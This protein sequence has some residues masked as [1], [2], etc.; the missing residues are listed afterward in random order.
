M[1][2]PKKTKNISSAFFNTIDFTAFS[3]SKVYEDLHLLVDKIAT[4]PY[5]Y[6]YTWPWVSPQKT[7]HIN[8]FNIRIK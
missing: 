5:S 2:K 7:T 3:G 1:T 4:S 8:G 6:N